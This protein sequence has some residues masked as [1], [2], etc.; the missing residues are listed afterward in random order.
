MIS[1]RDFLY[2][3]AATLALTRAAHP[4][5]ARFQQDDQV[6]PVPGKEGMIL[7][8][9]RFLDLET[10]VDYMDSWITPE[11]HF[12]VRNHM[13]MPGTIDPASWKLSISGE[14]E[15]P[16]SL[17]LNDLSKFPSLAV[18]NTL[19]CAGNGRAFQRP[20][21]PG[22]Q[23][24]RGAV[25]TGRFQGPR[26]RDVL[27]RAGVKPTGKHVSF[28]GLDQVPGKVPP[29]VRSIPIEKAMDAD[30][31]VATHM[32]GA[33]LTHFHGFPVRALVPGWIGAASCKWVAEIHVI[34]KEFDGNFMKPGYRYPNHAVEPGGSIS[35]DETHALTSLR[36]K[37]IIAGPVEGATVKAGMLHVHG[38][39]WAGED[40]IA[41]VDVSTD[42]GATWH[43]AQLGSDRARYAW[44]LWSFSWKPPRS[45][46]YTLMSRATDS[47]G[48][49]QPESAAW[50]PS[51]YLYNAIDK[52][53]VHVQT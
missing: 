1:R 43:A 20:I 32:N 9:Y 18:T 30:T 40:D 6:A 33:P 17:D 38:A 47:Q 14:V 5:L 11:K 51:G 31:I 28:R 52:V 21:V 53:K 34:D 42:S 27:M 24:Q 48:R 3:A 25:S 2:S 44:R 46:D 26:L 37:S 16:V 10:P 50:N 45:G 29:F 41:K 19:E 23:W 8:S 22:V 49:T 39:A 7:R 12:Y 4:L 15:N 13:Y 36:V 35:P